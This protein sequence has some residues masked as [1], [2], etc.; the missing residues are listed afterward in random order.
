M[1]NL[2]EIWGNKHRAAKVS[3][4]SP[5]TLRDWR[6]SGRIQENIHWVRIAKTKVLYNIPLLGDFISNI[7][8]SHAHHQ[9]V[10]SYLASLPSNQPKARGRRAG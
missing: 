3:G 9:A 10:D 8:D 7:G 1:H 2:T 5:L 6:L 4:L